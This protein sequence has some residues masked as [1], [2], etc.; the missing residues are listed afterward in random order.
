MSMISKRD[1]VE[2]LYR[3]NPMPPDMLAQLISKYCSSFSTE[4]LID[5]FNKATGAQIIYAGGNMFEVK[6][7]TN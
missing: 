3:A 2:I 6:Y 1:V 7:P 5:E 4:S